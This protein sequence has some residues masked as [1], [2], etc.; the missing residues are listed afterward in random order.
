MP[1]MKKKKNQGNG[2]IK[3]IKVQ[4]EEGRGEVASG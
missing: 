3:R 1:M 4:A 2:V